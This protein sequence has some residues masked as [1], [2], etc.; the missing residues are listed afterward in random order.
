MWRG[1]PLSIKPRRLTTRSHRAIAFEGKR[2]ASTAQ[3]SNGF[4]CYAKPPTGIQRTLRA[5]DE[6][7][8]FSE[9]PSWL[10]II[11]KMSSIVY[12]MEVESS[13]HIAQ[14]RRKAAMSTSRIDLARRRVPTLANVR[15]FSSHQPHILQPC[16]LPL[17]S[18]SQQPCRHPFDP[19]YLWSH[20]VRDHSAHLPQSAVDRHFFRIHVARVRS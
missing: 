9:L 4:S 6:D 7:P 18:L 5:W 1:P 17:A 14:W 20:L 19:F 12:K 10:G 2:H 8:R 16:A 3:S 11:S 15:I 13:Y